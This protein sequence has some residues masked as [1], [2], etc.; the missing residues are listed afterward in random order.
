[1]EY[2]FSAFSRESFVRIDDE[3]EGR[4]KWASPQQDLNTQ[5]GDSVNYVLS[6][7]NFA[8]FRGGMDFGEWQIAAFIDN[9]TD[10]HTVTNYEFS[11]DPGGAGPAYSRLQRD[12][13]F[14]PRTFGFTFT[15]RH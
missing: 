3:Y 14:R 4:S 10:T 13:T 2:K 1:L 6:P 11:I 9:L 12:F 5:Q 7:T 8:S 15:Y